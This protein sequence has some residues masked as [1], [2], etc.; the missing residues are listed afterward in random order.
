MR[1]MTR[2]MLS[3]AGAVLI[4]APMAHAQDSTGSGSP[5][6]HW[7]GEMGGGPMG[8]R[9]DDMLFRGINLTSAQR[10]SIAKLN[11]AHY[12]AMGQLLDSHSAGTP[13]DS[14]TRAQFHALRTQH[15]SDLRAVLT[16]DQQQIF[17]QNLAT[18][19]PRTEQRI[20]GGGGQGGNPSGNP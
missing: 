7:Q 5:R 17:D 15:R 14:A 2:Y 11:A 20:R 6:G 10:D 13:P 1:L 12:R 4:A 18:R 16:P 19:R 9:G 3:A 8:E